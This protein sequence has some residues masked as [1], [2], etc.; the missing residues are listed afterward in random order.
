MV[1]IGGATPGPGRGHT[2]GDTHMEAPRPMTRDDALRCDS[3]GRKQAHMR[4]LHVV[5]E[6]IY[7]G[8]PPEPFMLCDACMDENQTV[9]R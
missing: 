3:C 4:Y 6:P 5:I 2:K 7:M 9:A 1:R 8:S